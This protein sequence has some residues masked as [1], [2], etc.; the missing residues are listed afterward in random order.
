MNSS[1]IELRFW[2]WQRYT[3][4]LALPLVIL[5]VVLQYFVWGIDT[6]TFDAV[7]ARMKMAAFLA[8]DLMLLAVVT[9]HAFLGLRSIF[10]DYAKNPASA[11]RTTVLLAVTL[12]GVILY[13]LAALAAFL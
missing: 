5:H 13:G 3:A 1:L 10:M 8:L 4:L 9:T 11:Q 6:I 12:A 2:R 7:S